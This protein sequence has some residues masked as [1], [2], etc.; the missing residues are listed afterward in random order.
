MA[1]LSEWKPHDERVCQL[2]TQVR[3]IPDP[4]KRVFLVHRLATQGRKPLD[5]HG[6]VLNA[7]DDIVAQR[8]VR[9]DP[10]RVEMV[11][12]SGK[13][14]RNLWSFRR[15]R[16]EHMNGFEELGVVFLHARDIPWCRLQPER[17]S[18]L[19]GESIE[20]RERKMENA[21]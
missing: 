10:A 12:R 17:V 2:L 15:E 11:K 20:K 4:S 19:G 9:P 6:L 21:R 18:Q 8:D 3:A 5:A 7:F 16:H 1:A 14:R 13:L